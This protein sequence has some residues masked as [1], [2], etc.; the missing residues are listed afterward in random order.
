[1]KAIVTIAA[2]MLSAQVAANCDTVDQQSLPANTN[3]QGVSEAQVQVV[4]EA[5]VDSVERRQ[6]LLDCLRPAPFV[7]GSVDIELERVAEEF[8]RD[9]DVEHEAEVAAN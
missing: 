4:G 7:S 8:E 9:Q 3:S 2:F 5:I 1:M 6:A